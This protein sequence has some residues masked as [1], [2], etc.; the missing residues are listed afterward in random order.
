MRGSR[1]MDTT[2]ARSQWIVR[3]LLAFSV[4]IAVCIGP[5]S[6]SAEPERG[7]KTAGGLPTGS[8][9]ILANGYEGD[10]VVSSS[11]TYGNISGSVFG[12]PIKGLWD[13]FDR[14]VTF[15]TM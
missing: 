9:H 15:S 4:L 13:G 8:W 14:R 3:W 11:D 1:F 12:S 10:L 6:A 7:A 5:A 2:R